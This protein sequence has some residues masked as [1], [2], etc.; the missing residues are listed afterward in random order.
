MTQTPHALED[1]IS[2]IFAAA[3]QKL[4]VDADVAAHNGSFQGGMITSAKIRLVED[5]RTSIIAA[6]QPHIAADPLMG[7]YADAE[8]ALIEAVDNWIALRQ[9]LIASATEHKKR[10]IREQEAQ[11]RLANTAAHWAWFKREP[12]ARLAKAE[13]RALRSSFLFQ[14]TWRRRR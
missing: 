1:Q 9:P 3:L 2:G 11:F 13:G 7:S 4:A 12:R 14:W 8:R 10:D 5:L 6:L